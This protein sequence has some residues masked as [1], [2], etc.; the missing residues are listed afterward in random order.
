MIQLNVNI[1]FVNGDRSFQKLVENIQFLTNEENS[2]DSIQS[3]MENLEDQLAGIAFRV[4]KCE[5]QVSYI[6]KYSYSFIL[7][8]RL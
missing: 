6:C 3:K 4:S 5:D 8:L 2:V 7:G 1:P